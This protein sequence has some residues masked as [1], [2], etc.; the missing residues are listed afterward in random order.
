MAKSSK[1]K[2]VDV[3]ADSVF[4]DTIEGG[5]QLVK[6]L[7]EVKGGLKD[8]LLESKALLIANPF[9]N[10]KDLSDYHGQLKQIEVAQKHLVEL[11]IVKERLKQAQLKTTQQEIKAERDL[12][13]AVADEGKVRD[14]AAKAVADQGRAYVSLSKTL[15]ENKKAVKDLLAAG[16]D[17]TAEE[18]ALVK[19]TQDLDKK[20]KEIDATVGDNQRSVGAYKD[21]IKDALNETG[22]LGGVI[23]RVSA[24]FKR[25]RDAQDSTATS[26]K[27]FA[28][29]AKII[30]G[31]IAAVAIALFIAI[32]DAAVNASQSLS[33]LAD[34]TSI[35]IGLRRLEI[36]AAALAA[37]VAGANTN[38]KEA[39]KL[40]S[41]LV[42]QTTATAKAMRALSLEIQQA[43][44]DEVDYNEIANDTTIGF[45]ERANALE[46]AIALGKQKLQGELK[47]AELTLA[48]A[49]KEVAA[50]E[51][52]I[53]IGKAK[54]EL[55]E[56]QNNAL[57]AQRVAEDNLADTTRINAQREREQNIARATQEI[58]LLLKKKQSANAQAAMLEI[59]LADQKNQLSERKKINAQLLAVNQKTTAEEIAIFKKYVKIQFNENNL[60]KEQDAIRLKEKI[61]GLRTLEGKGLGEAAVSELSKIIKNNQDKQIENAKSLDAL[62]D[63]EIKKLQRIAAIGRDIAKINLEAQINEANIAKEAYILAY[64]KAND[65]ILNKGKLFNA[66]LNEQREYVFENQQSE[67]ESLRGLKIKLLEQI[68][69]SERIA[70]Q[71]SV[72]DNEI[73]AEEIRKINEKLKVDLHA[74]Y[75]DDVIQKKAAN[76]KKEEDDE[77]IALKQRQ[78][79]VD[80]VQQTAGH[81]NDALDKQSQRK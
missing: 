49:N 35:S 5:E 2:Q 4:K 66:K 38:V 7:E 61:E 80:T 6:V 9:K 28:A 62:K 40:F 44:L 74:I 16:R 47:A 27:K 73:R 17:L 29:S 65:E 54:K 45:I 23:E 48:L 42:D 13:K 60:L 68:A 56:A 52:N 50:S 34:K 79:V 57:M 43:A 37:S 8:V 3:I 20:L 77:R 18:K 15:N 64:E 53:G 63:E 32:K 11:D 39:V 51:A 30:A 26:G 21:A 75:N 1:I 46:K 69:E 22:A 31:G 25:F 24:S 59:E 71:A 76:K 78:E 33:D 67:A 58:D 14:K 19:S 12:G 81:I 10:S 55:Y 41:E 72:T 70:L 36:N